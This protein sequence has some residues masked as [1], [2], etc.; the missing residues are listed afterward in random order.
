MS[1]AKIVEALKEAV[2]GDLS[3]VTV[4]GQ[5]WVRKDEI[6][7]YERSYK[8][9]WDEIFR[10]RKQ[11]DDVVKFDDVARDFILAFERDLHAGKT[12]ISIQTHD[13]FNRLRSRLVDRI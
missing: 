8:S 5:I 2:A 12:V 10:V 6:E 1:A 9:M 11:R 7:N 13:A 3:R 4:E